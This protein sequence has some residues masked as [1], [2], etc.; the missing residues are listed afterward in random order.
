MNKIKSIVAKAVK[1]TAKIALVD[2]A[3]KTTCLVIYQPEVPAKLDEYKH[4]LTELEQ[5]PI[6][7]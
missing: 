4:F 6:R 5:E 1:S 3:N 7:H 2:D